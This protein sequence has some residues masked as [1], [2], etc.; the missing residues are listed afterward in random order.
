MTEVEKL[1]PKEIIPRLG[2]PHRIQNDNGPSFTLDISQNVGQELQIR[3]KLHAS[4]IPQ[5]IGKTEKM[6]HTIKKT[7]AKYARKCI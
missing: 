1:L 6:N 5:S 4:W 2:L 3:W 7:L